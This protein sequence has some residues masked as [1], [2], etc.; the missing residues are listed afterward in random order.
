MP[1]VSF[2]IVITRQQQQHFVMVSL[3]QCL[4]AAVP[5]VQMH[6]CDTASLCIL[7]FQFMI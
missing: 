2:M 4:L 3:L 1:A 5:D 7:Q 6:A